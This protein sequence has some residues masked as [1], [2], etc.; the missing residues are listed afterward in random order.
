MGQPRGARV[1]GRGLI[2][3]ATLLG[4]GAIALLGADVLGCSARSGYCA[5]WSVVG[6]LGALLFLAGLVVTAFS[7]RGRR[8]SVVEWSDDL[9]RSQS[10]SVPPEDPEGELARR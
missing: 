4:V 2:V 1:V 10:A 7:Y 5:A 8:S 3:G 6:L 9:A